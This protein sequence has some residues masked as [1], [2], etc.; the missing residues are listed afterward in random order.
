MADTSEVCVEVGDKIIHPLYGI[1]TVED[2]KKLNVLNEEQGFYVLNIKNEKL[3]LM[4]PEKE[5]LRGISVRKPSTKEMAME[6]METLKKA[7]E[8][9]EGSGV[10]ML[11]KEFTDKLKKGN[12]IDLAEVVR[13]CTRAE[14]EVDID[15]EIKKFLRRVKKILVQEL[16]IA[17]EQKEYQTSRELNKIFKEA[18]SRKNK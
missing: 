12:I 2:F 13:D 10:N 6:A 9:I 14:M 17:L 11:L 16:S 18:A 3:S 8:S 5:V 1:G 7:P 15:K 4:I